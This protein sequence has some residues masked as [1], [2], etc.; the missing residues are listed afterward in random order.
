MGM[1]RMNL[2]ELNIHQNKKNFIDLLSCSPYVEL[3]GSVS[4]IDIQEI[5]DMFCKGPIYLL[6]EK[7]AYE[8]LALKHAE[9][10]R[11]AETKE[12]ENNEE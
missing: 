12:E 4:S 2:R 7:E 9:E 11:N 10:V 1:V 8:Y 5:N 3:E 6:T